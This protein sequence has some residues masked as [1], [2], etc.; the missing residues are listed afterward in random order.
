MLC[1]NL[2]IWGDYATVQLLTQCAV[3]RSISAVIH[4]T[5]LKGEGVVVEGFRGILFDGK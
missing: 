5:S 4:L 1:V 2:C 3:F